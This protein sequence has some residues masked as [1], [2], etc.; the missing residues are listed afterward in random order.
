MLFVRKIPD[1][2]TANPFKE[3]QII[4]NFL[5]L[6]PLILRRWTAGQTEKDELQRVYDRAGDLKVIDALWN[7]QDFDHVYEPKKRNLEVQMKLD[8]LFMKR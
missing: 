6:F 7:E 8:R 2:L 1:S 4:I 5:R 3:I